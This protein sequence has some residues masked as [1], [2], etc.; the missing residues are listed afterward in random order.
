MFL[1]HTGQACQKQPSTNTAKRDVRKKKSGRPGTVFRC[2]RQPDICSSRRTFST[3][4]SVDWFPTPR[5][6]AISAD[7]AG[8]ESGSPML[9]QPDQL[10]DAEPRCGVRDHFTNGRFSKPARRIEE[11]DG[12]TD[13]SLRHECPL[14][15]R[16]DDI[17][18]IRRASPADNLPI[19]KPTAM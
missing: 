14:V 8:F 19:W 7:R 11:N 17:F 6:F 13:V 4:T 15:E 12:E 5:T 1:P 16:N 3:Q 18:P 10:L 2:F 9:F